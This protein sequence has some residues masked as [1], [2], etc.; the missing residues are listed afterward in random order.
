MISLCNDSSLY[1]TMKQLLS[2]DNH[3]LISFPDPCQIRF[4]YA[5]MSGGDR[6]EYFHF[7]DEGEVDWL[8]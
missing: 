7:R 5:G 3:S 4:L 6:C 2:C 8:V 1:I